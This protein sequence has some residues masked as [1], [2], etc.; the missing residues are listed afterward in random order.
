MITAETP[1]LLLHLDVVERNLD[2][3]AARARELGVRL[4]PHVKTHKCPELGR[5]QAARGVAGITVATLA[6][7]E[8]F[9][10]A[11]FDD[12][13]WAFPLDP[14][15]LSRARRVAER[16]LLR[17][18]VDDLDTARRLRHT[19]L[20]AWLKV[21]CGYHRAGVDPASPYALR[22]ARELG[23]EQGITFDGILSHSGHAYRT[24]SR[25]EAAR[26]AEDERSVMVWFAELLRRDG[27]PVRGISV[28]STPAM[29]A[30]RTL[31]GVTE[32]RPGNYVFYDR[33]M[34]LIGACDLA[35]VGVTV[36]TTVVSHQPG[37]SHFVVDAGALALSKDPGPG[38]VG[39]P[40]MGAI[41]G[42]PDL[43]LASLSQEHGIVRAPAPQTI[44]GRFPV[45]E[46][47]EIIPN[48][49]CLT[50]AHFD[51]YLVVRESRVVDRWPIV[52]TR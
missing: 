33:T 2:R 40:A 23:S 43:V 38:H 4:R 9:A 3:M 19:G 18:V 30:V 32:A 46:R 14:G 47:L 35:D 45:G 12:I 10:G 1:A 8:A 22:V 51:E 17:V 31:E 20:H 16:A 48:H 13:T 36:L 27:L 52:R 29:V 5:R 39:P 28:G 49:S 41:Q 11:G 50:V 6:E 34:A 15:H 42:H 21:D 24:T 37:A 44:E 25:E 7:A 26:V